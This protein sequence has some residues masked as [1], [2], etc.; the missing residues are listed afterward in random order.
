M[1]GWAFYLISL[2]LYLFRLLANVRQDTTID[3]KDVAIYCF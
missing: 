2:R 1:Q 3:I